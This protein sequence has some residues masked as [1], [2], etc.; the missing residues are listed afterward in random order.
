M[1][2]SAPASLKVKLEQL[3]V[4]VQKKG[5]ELARHQAKNGPTAGG[6]IALDHELLVSSYKSMFAKHLDTELNAGLLEARFRILD[7][8][9]LGKEVTPNR[10]G[11]AGL[12]AFVGLAMG[13]MAVFGLDRRQRRL[14]A[15]K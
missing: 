8:P 14:P 12:G 9:Q 10:A 4:R 2:R 1:S 5:D 3:A 11:F 15:L 6:I 13:G 7:A